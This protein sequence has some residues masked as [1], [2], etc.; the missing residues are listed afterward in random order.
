MI[1]IPEIEERM[2]KKTNGESP[3]QKK[4]N[5]YLS[6]F[7]KKTASYLWSIYRTAKLAW[8]SSSF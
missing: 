7:L 5:E 1:K 3:L 6:F 4:D 2:V 8:N